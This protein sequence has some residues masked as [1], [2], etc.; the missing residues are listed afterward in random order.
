MFTIIMVSDSETY[1]AD[2]L[3]FKD[4]TFEYNL[5]NFDALVI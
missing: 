5:W 4:G 2:R 1:V 3:T